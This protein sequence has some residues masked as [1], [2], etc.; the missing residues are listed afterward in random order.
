VFPKI[1]PIIPVRRRDLLESAEW[2]NELRHDGFRALAYV[3][4]GRCRLISRRR[5]AF[6]WTERRHSQN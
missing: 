5:L 2:L 4:D 1:A 3:G 6:H